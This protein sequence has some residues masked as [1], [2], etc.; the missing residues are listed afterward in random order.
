M[1]AEWVRSVCM[2]LPRTTEEVLWGADLVFKIGGKMY[3]AAALEPGTEWLSFK[4]TP[5]KF[6]ELTE[7]EGIIP[8]PYAARYHWVALQTEDALPAVEIK[9]L[10]GESYELVL[11]KL[12]KKAQAAIRGDQENIHHGNAE[13]RR[14]KR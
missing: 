9:R 13:T 12:S 11:E 2:K 14:K 6:A 1:N 3:A 10:I 4:C 5:E 8:A 7:R